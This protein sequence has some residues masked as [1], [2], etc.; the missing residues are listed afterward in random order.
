[1][2]RLQLVRRSA[3]S[4][5]F[6][7]QTCRLDRPQLSVATAR[8]E[9]LSGRLHPSEQV[10]TAGFGKPTPTVPV[11]VPQRVAGTEAGNG[12]AKH[13]PCCVVGAANLE[14]GAR[15]AKND[16]ESAGELKCPRC[17]IEMDCI[18]YHGRPSWRVLVSPTHD[19]VESHGHR[20]A[21][22]PGSRNVGI[23]PPHGHRRH[24]RPCHALQHPDVQNR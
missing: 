8:R 19:R 2:G 5:M 18:S 3:L 4:A 9:L 16:S 24:D 20:S 21:G 6:R 14:T 11:A 7:S 23:A 1:M 12:K 15:A 13:W 10:L 17:K 22:M